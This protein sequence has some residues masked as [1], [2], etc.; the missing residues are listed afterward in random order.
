MR[1][2]R[3]NHGR[4]G[5]KRLQKA[6]AIAK[7]GRKNWHARASMW[8]DGIGARRPAKH[9]PVVTLLFSPPNKAKHYLGSF[10]PVTYA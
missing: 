9:L 7:A 8:L 2:E 10:G 3:I 6:R 5:P 1:L 4:R